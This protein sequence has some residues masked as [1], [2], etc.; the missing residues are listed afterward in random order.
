MTSTRATET[1]P[2][3]VEE[4]TCPVTG[5]T[6]LGHEFIPAG[7]GDIRSVCP[8]IN[9]MANHGYI[10]RDGKNITPLKIFRGLRA[11]YGL[12][13]PLAIVLVSGGWFFI[14]RYFGQAITLLDLG[15]HGGVEHDASVV[16]GDT[17]YPPGKPHTA[18]AR[19]GILAPI[20]IHPELVDEFVTSI[21]QRATKEANTSEF[22]SPS[23][24]SS[25]DLVPESAVLVNGHDIVQTR[26]RREK[27]S[28]PL[29]ALH[30][31]VARGEMA[32]ILGVW[33]NA[34][35]LS[36]AR[37]AAFQQEPG[38]PLPWLHRWLAD[39]RLPDGWRPTHTQG[40]RDVMRR[41]SAM[42]AEMKSIRK[43]DKTK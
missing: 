1:Q 7:E 41:S 15:A 21:R 37:N 42:R 34:S 6:G 22:V 25:A 23:S 31:E 32:I 40:L 43:G 29:D 18:T 28:P 26:L 14:K 39:E 17:P 5:Q 13:I 19:D 35:P 8:A 2:R 20:M 3:N 38:I 33:E 11:C 24:S 27:L 4:R 30:A 10:P 36:P 16:H 12:S 9:T